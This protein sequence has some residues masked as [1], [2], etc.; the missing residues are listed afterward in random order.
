MQTQA[1]K[2]T[3]CRKALTK[4]LEKFV[5][6]DYRANWFSSS[7]CI[8]NI[9]PFLTA[10]VQEEAGDDHAVCQITSER[11]QKSLQ[12]YFSLYVAAHRFLFL[13]SSFFKYVQMFLPWYSFFL[14]SL[15][16]VCCLSV[17]NLTPL[18]CLSLR[19]WCHT[20]HSEKH[21]WLHQCKLHQCESV[22]PHVF[23]SQQY[24]SVFCPFE[25]FWVVCFC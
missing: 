10:T 13:F 1:H 21:R 9:V 19:R 16:A 25:A 15:S 8:L 3:H 2:L 23:L 14:F 6:I 17:C 5:R 11:F 22:R 20:S 18:S 7:Y 12:R 24:L 4:Y